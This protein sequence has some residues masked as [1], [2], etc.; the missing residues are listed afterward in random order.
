MGRCG[1]TSPG[2]LLGYDLYHKAAATPLEH[3]AYI[4][5]PWREHPSCRPP[6]HE[7]ERVHTIK[8]IIEYYSEEPP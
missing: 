3:A 1:C 5:D 4:S 2:S 6:Y 8:I 7:E